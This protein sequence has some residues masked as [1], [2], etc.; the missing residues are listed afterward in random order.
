M[1]Q[2]QSSSGCG[3]SQSVH[4]GQ[5]AARINAIIPSLCEKAPTIAVDLL[6]TPGT[7]AFSQIDFADGG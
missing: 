7:K 3:R 6:C 5:V 4:P 1:T 2:R